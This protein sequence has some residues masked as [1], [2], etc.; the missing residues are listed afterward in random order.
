VNS[1]YFVDLSRNQYSLIFSSG[2]GELLGDQGMLWKG[3]FMT[4]TLLKVALI[5]NGPMNA[6][7]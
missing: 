2:H 4:D 3:P 1:F 6:T 7:G 5:I